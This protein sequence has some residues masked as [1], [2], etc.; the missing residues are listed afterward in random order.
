MNKEQLEALAREAGITIKTEDGTFVVDILRDRD[1]SFEL[2]LVRKHQ[3]RFIYMDD[4][5]LSLFAKG[6][7]TREIVARFKKMY[8]TDDSSSLISKVTD[9]VIERLVDYL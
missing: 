3:T 8:D 7:T 1:S 2:Q 5:I 6:I 4:K 9:S